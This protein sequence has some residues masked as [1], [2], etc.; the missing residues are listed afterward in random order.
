ML[1]ILLMATTKKVTFGGQL[2]KDLLETEKYVLV[3]STDKVEGGPFTR[4]D[5][6][7]PKCVDKMSCL[8]LVIIS[9]D[10][11][12]YVDKLSIDKEFKMTACHP[13]SKNK[14]V[15]PDHISVLL[16]FK[17][18]PLKTSQAKA[19]AKFCIWNTNKE[20]G[21]D[22]FKEL[23]EDNEKLLEVARDITGDVDVMMKTIDKELNRINMFPLAKLKLTKSLNQIKY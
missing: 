9:V 8:E 23:T 21:W 20:G 1:V 11:L 4:Y 14:V 3:N 7:D 6:S 13:L 17:G 19:G 22:K 15:Y 10:M 18:L 5:P 12:K 2:V 16:V